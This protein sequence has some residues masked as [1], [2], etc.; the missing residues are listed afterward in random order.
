VVISLSEVPGKL[1]IKGTA[2]WHGERGVTHE[3]ALNGEVEPDGNHLSYREG[4]PP[5]WGCVVSLTMVGKYIVADDNRRCG[6][7]NVRF[8]GIW[9]RAN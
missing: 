8:W 7:L 6:A 9:K 3:G 4:Q 5:E 1:G 2:E